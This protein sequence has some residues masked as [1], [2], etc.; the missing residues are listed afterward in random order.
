[1]ILTW[2]LATK[3]SEPRVKAS[4]NNTNGFCH[5]LRFPLVYVCVLWVGFH[6]PKFCLTPLP[7]YASGYW[8]DLWNCPGQSMWDLWCIMWPLDS[9]FSDY[10]G[11]PLWLSRNQH[12][13]LVFLYLHRR[14]L[15]LSTGSSVKKLLPVFV[16]G[17]KFLKQSLTKCAWS[18]I[19]LIT[20]S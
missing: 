20:F 19:T 4:C 10:I 3:F 7:E 5:H 9:F 6:C 8:P 17:Y 12:Y 2:N 11:L 14:H 13:M 1:M 15:M 16:G 18:R